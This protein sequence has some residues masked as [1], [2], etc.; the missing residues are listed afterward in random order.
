MIHIAYSHGERRV[1]SML[2][3]LLNMWHF[4]IRHSAFFWLQATASDYK[5]NVSLMRLWPFSVLFNKSFPISNNCMLING[6]RP[7]LHRKNTPTL[8]YWILKKKN[9]FNIYVFQILKSTTLT[10]IH[11]VN[12]STWNSCCLRQWWIGLRYKDC[13]NI[14]YFKQNVIRSIPFDKT[15]SCI[16]SELQKKN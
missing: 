14:W 2:L 13:S 15:R 4:G 8:H 9:E 5:S 16:E 3:L 6:V 1:T 12:E 7:W 10:T 11:F